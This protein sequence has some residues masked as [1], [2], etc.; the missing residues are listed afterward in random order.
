MV[1]D[2]ADL[3]NAI[4]L[5]SALVN[6]SRVI[7]PVVAAALV[8]VAGVGGCYAVDA[9]SYLAVI[10]SLLAMRVAP[11]PPRPHGGAVLAQMRDGFRYVRQ[12]HLVRSLL[13]LIAIT[14]AFGGAYMSLL[15]AYA[16]GA[17]HGGADTLGWLMGAGGAGAVVGVVILAGREGVAGLERVVA[18]CGLTLGLGLIALELAPSVWIAAPILFV[19]GAALILQYS[20]TNTLLQSTVDEDKLGRVMS[21]Y[22]LSVFAGAPV[23]ALLEGSLANAIGTVHTFALAGL[24]CVVC[25]LVFRGSL[26]GATDSTGSR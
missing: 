4:A 9:A 10:A 14:G 15:P 26:P 5:N 23:G 16:A 18:G 13:V 6:A 7:G 21:L 12:L 2:R 1:D 19:V 3:P 17:L 22:L 8:V 24:A 20:A 25:S 11:Q